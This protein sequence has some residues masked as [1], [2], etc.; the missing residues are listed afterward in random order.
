[1]EVNK[2]NYQTHMKG[3]LK[4]RKEQEREKQALTDRIGNLDRDI[5][6]A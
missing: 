6:E 1:M 3:I 2:K 4:F 5:A